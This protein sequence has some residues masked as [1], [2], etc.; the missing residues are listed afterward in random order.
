[1]LQHTGQSWSRISEQRWMLRHWSIPH[2]LLTCVQLIFTC[3]FERKSALNGWRFCDATGIKNATEELKRP[4]QNGF[5]ACS[6]QLYSR[7][8]KCVTAKWDFWRKWSLSDYII[9]CVL[10]IKVIPGTFWSY[11]VCICLCVYGDTH[12]CMHAQQYKDHWKVDERFW[13]FPSQSVVDRDT[14][15]LHGA[16]FFFRS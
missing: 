14:Y 12:T 1:M 16:E 4:L 10:E 7:W 15:L 11:Q 5:Q 6:Q 9:L 8:P 13:Q 2:P 3:S